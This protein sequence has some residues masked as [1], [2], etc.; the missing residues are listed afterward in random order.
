MNKFN[1]CSL[2]KINVLF[3]P[4]KTRAISLEFLQL[5]NYKL[6]GIVQMVYYL[7]FNLDY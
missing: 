3:S 1:Q 5:N 7:V 6:L 2:T 4:E